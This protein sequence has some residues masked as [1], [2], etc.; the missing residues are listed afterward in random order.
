MYFFA[1]DVLT[2]FE[3][4]WAIFVSRGKTITLPIDIFYIR[5]DLM[6]KEKKEGKKRRGKKGEEKRKRKKKGNGGFC[7][8]SSSGRRYTRVRV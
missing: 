6:R 3:D 7:S 5:K 8:E 4:V 1:V 2:R